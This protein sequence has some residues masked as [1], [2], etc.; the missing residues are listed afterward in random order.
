M[1]DE[2]IGLISQFGSN[3]QVCLLLINVGCITDATTPDVSSEGPT[4]PPISNSRRRAFARNVE[5]LLI[6]FR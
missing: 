2:R 4:D 1:R 5:I 6:F 3:L